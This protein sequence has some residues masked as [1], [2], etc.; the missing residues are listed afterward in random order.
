MKS[1]I[2]MILDILSGLWVTL[3]YSMFLFGLAVMFFDVWCGLLI[4][5]MMAVGYILAYFGHRFI[6]YFMDYIEKHLNK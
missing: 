5:L 2:R 4:C 1:T 6:V 3:M